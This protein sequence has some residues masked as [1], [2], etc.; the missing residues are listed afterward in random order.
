[1]LFAIKLYIKTSIGAKVTT[2]FKASSCFLSFQ[3]HIPCKLVGSKRGLVIT[4]NPIEHIARDCQLEQKM[5]NHS[6]QE[7]SDNKDNKQKD[8]GEGSK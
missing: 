1:M 5:K 7:E 6:I 8:F 4:E 3:I 2:F